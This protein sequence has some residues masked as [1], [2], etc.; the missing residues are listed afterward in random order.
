MFVFVS[1]HGVTPDSAISKMDIPAYH[2]KSDNAVQVEAEHASEWAPLI[3]LVDIPRAVPTNALL[4][5]HRAAEQETLQ[6]R[7][8]ASQIHPFIGIKNALRRQV[9]NDI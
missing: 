1:L 8:K 6:H 9:K 4:E 3:A 2:R 5:K 7:R